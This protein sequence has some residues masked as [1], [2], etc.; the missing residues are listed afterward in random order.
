MFTLI[1]KEIVKNMKIYC[2][3]DL[4]NVI[5]ILLFIIFLYKSTNKFNYN[6]VIYNYFL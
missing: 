3:F 4:K 5:V 2:I 6:F 1:C